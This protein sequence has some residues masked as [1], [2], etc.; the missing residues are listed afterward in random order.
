MYCSMSG[1]LLIMVQLELISTE[2]F[3]NKIDGNNSE[4]VPLNISCCPLGGHKKDNLCASEM[5]GL[6]P[7]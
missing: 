5:R 2:A 4:V 3:L 1:H 7:G 6:D